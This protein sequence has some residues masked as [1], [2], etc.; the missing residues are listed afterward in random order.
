MVSGKVCGQEWL[1]QY[2]TNLS[3]TN[4]KTT[5]LHKQHTVYYFGNVRKIKAIQ[6]KPFPPI[7]SKENM[8]ILSNFTYSAIDSSGC[9][10]LFSFFDSINL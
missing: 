10:L 2:I 8:N 5:N 6:N 7:I 4:K 1:K 9:D 3:K